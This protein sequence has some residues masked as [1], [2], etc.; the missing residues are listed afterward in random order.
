MSSR[1]NI[2][3]SITFESEQRNIAVVHNIILALRADKAFFLGCR[4]ASAGFEIVKCYYL[5][6]DKSAF[7]IGVYLAG[8]L[9]RLCS[10]AYRPRSALVAAAGEEGYQAKQRIRGLYHAIKSRLAHAQLFQ[11]TFRAHPAQGPRSQLR[12][13]RR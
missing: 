5:G 2:T 9:G 4:H 12:A 6:A 11:G 3:S 13:S 7:E 10:A 1:T 8:G